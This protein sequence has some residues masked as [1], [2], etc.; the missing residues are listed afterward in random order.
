MWE[1]AHLRISEIWL[2]ISTAESN[3]IQ[4]SAPP[5]S[6]SNHLLSLPAA[7]LSTLHCVLTGPYA[8]LCF[9]TDLPIMM[10]LNAELGSH[11]VS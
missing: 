8:H 9:H 6:R 4:L 7:G 1:K 5:Q 3:L 2:V 11:V 10:L